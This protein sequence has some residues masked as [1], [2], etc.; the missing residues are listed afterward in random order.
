MKL[1]DRLDAATKE[2]V[3]LMSDME[4]EE[5]RM[6]NNFLKQLTEVKAEKE[7]METLVRALRKR[8]EEVKRNEEMVGTTRAN[9]TVISDYTST[10]AYW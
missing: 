7:K 2:K 4:Q 6:T 3:L 8:L 5:E 1:V 10:C 9:Y